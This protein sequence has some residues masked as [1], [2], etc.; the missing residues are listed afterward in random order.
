MKGSEVV[1]PPRSGPQNLLSHCWTEAFALLVVASVRKVW[2]ADRLPV[3]PYASHHNYV[4]Q[5]PRA[6]PADLGA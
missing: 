5:F 1:D 6:S 3:G 2:R 4:R